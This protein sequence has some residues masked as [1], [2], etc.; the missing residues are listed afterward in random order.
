MRKVET[1]YVFYTKLHT[2]VGKLPVHDEIL[3]KY[4]CSNFASIFSIIKNAIFSHHGATC[5]EVPHFANL[6]ID[7]IIF[8]PSPVSGHSVCVLI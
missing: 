4:A 2:S 6:G 5:V 1:G 3:N 7:G 8:C